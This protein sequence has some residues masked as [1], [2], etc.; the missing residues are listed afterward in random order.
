MRAYTYKEKKIKNTFQTRFE[1]KDV[2]FEF[3]YALYEAQAHTLLRVLVDSRQIKDIRWKQSER[4][5]L[6]EK[7][8]KWV[9][10]GL[11]ATIESDL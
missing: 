10:T 1:I 2:R 7:G 5:Y 8:K 4:M 3:N 6:H 9:K 11:S